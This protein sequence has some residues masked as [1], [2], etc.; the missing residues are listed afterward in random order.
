MGY[1]SAARLLDISR[2][3]DQYLPSINRPSILELGDQTLNLKENDIEII[4]EFLKKY[5]AD[6]NLGKYSSRIGEQIYV[7]EIYKDAG[8]KHK[9]LD[10][11]GKD[12][13]LTIDLNLW[14]NPELNESNFQKFD[15]ITNF[16]T[17]EHV[18]NQLNAFA[19]IHYL[20]KKNGVI[21]H[22]IPMLNYSSHAMSVATPLLLQ[23][24]INWN[25][26]EIKK[27]KWE[28][29]MVNEAIDF[30]YNSGMCYIENYLKTIAES[31]YSAMGL[32]VLINS[33]ASKFIPPLD[34]DV[35]GTSERK[36]LE[37]YIEYYTHPLLQYQ[38]A[39]RIE[40]VYVSPSITEAQ[41]VKMEQDTRYKGRKGVYTH[42]E[43]GYALSIL[44]H[45]GKIKLILY[46]PS[47]KQK[48]KL[49]PKFIRKLFNASEKN[50]F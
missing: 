3:C 33:N 38:S 4:S 17:T 39:S 25:G 10:L 14:P 49:M 40:Q 48:I 26:Y 18:A 15:L 24:L 1:S 12:N 9:C 13:A 28:T 47:K 36:L 11:N 43:L 35:T 45:K 41:I 6:S 42:K 31:T 30:H 44:R 50:G 32:F 23:K 22:H 7:S 20:S 46:T 5:S 16:G 2:Y 27:A 37:S 21:L 34:V 8:F 19:I 29:S